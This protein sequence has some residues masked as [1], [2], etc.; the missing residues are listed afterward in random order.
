MRTL[1]DARRIAREIEAVPEGERKAWQVNVLKHVRVVIERLDAIAFE[2]CD[3]L[4]I[5]VPDD[6]PPVTTP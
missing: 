6:A 1:S 3:A 2:P 4:R 5:G